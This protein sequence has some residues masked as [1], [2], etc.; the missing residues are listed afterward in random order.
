MATA[1]SVRQVVRHA[2]RAGF[3]VVRW[4]RRVGADVGVG[5]E[6]PPPGADERA[7][8]DRFYDLLVALPGPPPAED[9]VGAVSR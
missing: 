7:A 2:E 1:S 3:R 6:A 8:F 5:F 4:D 9:P